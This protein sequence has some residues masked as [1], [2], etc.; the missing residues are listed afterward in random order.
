MLQQCSDIIPQRRPL[1]I[2]IP[3]IRP[4]IKRHNVADV[5]LEQLLDRVRIWL[6][7]SAS[8]VRRWPTRIPPAT[9]RQS[10]DQFIPSH[11]D[12]A[13]SSTA[14]L[15]DLIMVLLPAAGGGLAG[16][17]IGLWPGGGAA[18]RTSAGSAG[19]SAR[20]G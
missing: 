20:C 17:T 10:A 6:H 3:D 14:V 4:L 19:R 16:G 11:L 1:M 12:S 5:P 13:R 9:E 8:L 7:S 2:L 18:T 15:R